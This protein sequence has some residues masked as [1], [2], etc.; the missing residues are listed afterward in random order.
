MRQIIVGI[1]DTHGGHRLGLIQPDTVLE[2]YSKDGNLIQEAVHPTECQT[3]LIDWQEQCIDWIARF[4][5]HD[6]VTLIHLGDPAHGNGHATE[7]VS[8]RMAD[9]I[10]IARDNLLRWIRGTGAHRAIMCTGTDVHEFMEGSA[11]I[12]IKHLAGHGAELYNHAMIDVEGFRID[13]AHHGPPPG[14]RAWLRGNVARYYA[15]S[16]AIN[17]VFQGK[18]PPD[19]IWRGHVHTPLQEMIRL[20]DKW[21]RM[22]IASPFCFPGAYAL[23]VTRSVNSVS[24]GVQVLELVDG[25][26]ASD[27]VELIQRVDLR[28]EVRL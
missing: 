1:S 19:L 27:P 23:K 15:Q 20:N 7:L 10:I 3:A 26:L 14:S 28:Q 22:M 16:L 12:L 13:A 8:T 21:V 9:Q 25:R 11:S 4:A 17:D 24:Y 2:G 6:R 18:V 5:G